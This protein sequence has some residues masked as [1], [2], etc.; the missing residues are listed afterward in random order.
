MAWHCYEAN[1]QE[2]YASPS[3]ASESM[4]RSMNSQN[5]SDI[6]A[7]RMTYLMYYVAWIYVLDSIPWIGYLRLR[8]Y[9]Q[10]QVYHSRDIKPHTLDKS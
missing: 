4:K 5:L 10:E 2:A 8:R 7:M 1:H 3:L 9:R 6:A